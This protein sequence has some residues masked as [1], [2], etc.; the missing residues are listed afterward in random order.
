M[1]SHF[2]NG[3]RLPLSRSGLAGISVTSSITELIE[4]NETYRRLGIGPLFGDI[5]DRFTFATKTPS[6]QKMALY[7][8]HDTTVAAILA[9]MGVYDNRWPFF[10]SNITFELFKLQKTGLLTFWTRDQYFVRVRYNQEVLSLPGI[11]IYCLV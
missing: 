9:T 8:T 1:T 6:S 11:Q 2:E 10:T 4:E 3:L 5:L 7:G